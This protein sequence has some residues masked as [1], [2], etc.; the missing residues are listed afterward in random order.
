MSESNRAPLAKVYPPWLNID[1]HFCQNQLPHS[2]P[3]WYDLQQYCTRIGPSSWE[4]RMKKHLL[5]IHLAAQILLPENQH[6]GFN[7]NLTLELEDWIIKREQG[8]LYILNTA[9]ILALKDLS[10]SL[11]CAGRC[12]R[13]SLMSSGCQQSPTPFTARI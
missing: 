3:W 12:L 2:V 8:V 6:N 11:V 9:S 1:S 7:N 13:T 10:T 5:P 4:S